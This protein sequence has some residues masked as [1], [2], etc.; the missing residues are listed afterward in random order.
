MAAVNCLCLLP[1]ELWE[2]VL[3]FA[4]EYGPALEAVC[5]LWRDLL[6]GL[7][8]LSPGPVLSIHGLARRG[9]ASL[10][11]WALRRDSEPGRWPK[12]RQHPLHWSDGFFRVILAGAALGGH[13]ALIL[14]WDPAMAMPGAALDDLATRAG[15][16][17]SWDILAWALAKSDLGT[18]KHLMAPALFESFV[19]AVGASEIGRYSEILHSEAG[20]SIAAMGQTLISSAVTGAAKGGQTKMLAKL[21]RI[22]ASAGCDLNLAVVARVAAEGGCANTVREL[23]AWVVGGLGRPW[24]P[25][26]NSVVL[27]G[28]AGGH[29]CMIELAREW[30]ADGSIVGEAFVVA[31]KAGRTDVMAC[32]L[33]WD[34]WRSHDNAVAALKAAAEH[35]RPGAVMFSLKCG[36]PCD[37][38][39]VYYMFVRWTAAQKR[40]A[41]DPDW[42]QAGPA[43]GENELIEAAAECAVRMGWRWAEV[44]SVAIQAAEACA[45]GVENCTRAACALLGPGVAGA[46]ACSPDELRE[47]ARAARKRGI[48]DVAAA[49]LAAIE[50]LE[51]A[52]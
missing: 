45:S 23:C 43:P 33:E 4:R 38:M 14:Q 10:L 7:S 19:G 41:S 16:S 1:A 52:Q 2:L 18:K 42:L 8:R 44:V 35:G 39:A 36:A 17:G 47:V 31:A 32:C 50:R 25:M 5:S 40:R 24:E 46:A 28:A 30:G 20:S 21:L 51:P 49:A 37:R 6:A 34:S 13:L 22:A 48:P 12:F 3:G 26:V 9:H 11:L 27:G 29:P 15:I